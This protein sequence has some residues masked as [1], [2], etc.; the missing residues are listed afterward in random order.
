M[1]W[2]IDRLVGLWIDGFVGLWIDGVMDRW[3][4]GMM[5]WWTESSQLN[6]PHLI[7]EI[8]YQETWELKRVRK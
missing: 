2:W 8:N 4:D 7:L 3:I 1:A 6:S 5:D